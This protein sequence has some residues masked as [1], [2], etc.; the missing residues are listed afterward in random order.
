MCAYVRVYMAACVLVCVCACVRVY[1]CVCV[2]VCACV[3]VRPRICVRVHL[4]VCVGRWVGTSTHLSL[5]SIHQFVYL[6]HDIYPS[7]STY[8]C[9]YINLCMYPSIMPTDNEEKLI[10]LK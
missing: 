7:T 6:C 4:C 10:T 1:V 2:R 9:S 8:L 3:R 5:Y